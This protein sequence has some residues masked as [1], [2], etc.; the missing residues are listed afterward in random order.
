MVMEWYCAN[1]GILIYSDLFIVVVFILLQYLTVTNI[2]ITTEN[3]RFVEY[4]KGQREGGGYLWI[5]ECNKYIGMK[6]EL[7]T[8]RCIMKDPK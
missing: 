7:S 1:A 8:T 2:R 3:P 5:I 4:T 6:K